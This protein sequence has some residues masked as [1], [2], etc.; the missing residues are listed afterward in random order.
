M[1]LLNAFVAI[2]LNPY[3]GLK[4]Y[5]SSYQVTATAVAIPL[6]PYQGLKRVKAKTQS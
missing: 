1:F 4:R 6:N 2:P 5:C 3:Q